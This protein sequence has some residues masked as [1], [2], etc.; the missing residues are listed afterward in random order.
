MLGSGIIFQGRF[1]GG[2]RFIPIEE[3]DSAVLFGKFE[4]LTAVDFSNRELHAFLFEPTPGDKVVI[5]TPPPF[6][7]EGH[8][9]HFVGDPMGFEPVEHSVQVVLILPKKEVLGVS[10]SGGACER[11][12]AFYLPGFPER[13]DVDV[14]IVPSE[15][16]KGKP[17]KLAVTL[18][19]VDGRQGEIPVKWIRQ[20]IDW[21]RFEPIFETPFGDIEARIGDFEE[22]LDVFVPLPI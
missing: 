1:L 13:F 19:V 22:A 10:N 7:V 14:C 15:H 12:T 11:D 3:N 21:V 2:F 8:T 16:S 20:V 18:P 17:V 5:F 4:G 6:K 9:S